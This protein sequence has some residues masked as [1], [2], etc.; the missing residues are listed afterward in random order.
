MV[1]TRRLNVNNSAVFYKSEHNIVIMLRVFHA[2]SHLEKL[3][4]DLQ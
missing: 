1:K 3:I 2:L 4:K